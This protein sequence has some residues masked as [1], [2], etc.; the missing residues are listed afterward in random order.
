M[1]TAI[2]PLK[3]SE[4]IEVGYSQANVEVNQTT[5]AT[6]IV[7]S[8]NIRY[9]VGSYLI[10]GGLLRKAGLRGQ[11]GRD[12]Q[13]AQNISAAAS[14][15]SQGR[16]LPK[17]DVL[18]LQE[19]DKE[20]KRAGRHHVARE[21]AEALQ[22]NWAHAPA[23]IPRGVKPAVREWW[24]D[25]EEPIDLHDSG[26]TGIALLSRLALSDIKRIDLPWH[27][28]AWRPRLAM[29][30]TVS[31]GANRLRI[32]N[33]HVDPHAAVGDQL[34]QLE[35]L[36]GQA[37]KETE[38]TLILGD[39]NT[40]SKRK[41]EETRSFLESRGYTTPFTSGTPTWRGMGIRLY[42]DWMFSRG[43]KLGRCGVARPL[44]VSDHWPIWAEIQLLDA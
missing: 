15:F 8:Y 38:P 35:V 37:E 14:A 16:L 10:S 34:E 2:P 6:I 11:G 40:L 1:A 3:D 4:K 28:C 19:A 21:L 33:A 13:V 5:P 20:T 24:L 41:V 44:S 27:E 29:A 25:F 23:G 26:D 17:V 32:Y 30:A 7:A 43:V 22:M 36:T 31:I 42:A 39:F 12:K 9:A 18:A